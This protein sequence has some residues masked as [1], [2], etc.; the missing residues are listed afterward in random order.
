MKKLLLCLAILVSGVAV[1]SAQ[2]ITASYGGYTQM[3]VVNN[4]KGLPDMKTCWGA[5]NLSLYVPVSN[6]VK[7]GPSYSYSSSFTKSEVNFD[8]EGLLFSSRG[9]A[10]YHTIL[11]NAKVK[12]YENSIVSVYGHAGAGIVIANTRRSNLSGA[13]NK[14][15][16]A[17]QISPVGA[18][19]EFAPG[20]SIFGE[21]GFGAQGLVQVGLSYE[22]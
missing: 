21:V 22:F 12:Y 4:H 2:E 8:S 20:A 1:A 6:R 18:Q 13:S 15:Y 19:V 7:I 14:G 11:L 9:K 5:V 17:G 3:D 10:C 16:F